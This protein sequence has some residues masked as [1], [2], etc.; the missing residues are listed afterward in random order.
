MNQIIIN[1]FK[2]CYLFIDYVVCEWDVVWI[3]IWLFVGLVS[4]VVVFGDYFLFNIGVELIIVIWIKVG[5]VVVFYN[6]CKYCGNCLVWLEDYIGCVEK[7][8]CLYYV[9]IYDLDG[10]LCLVFDCYCFSN[11][12]FED[13]FF[14]SFFFLEIWYGF[15]FVFMSDNFVFFDEFMGFIMDEL[16]FYY[17]DKFI[18]VVDQFCF[19][20]CNWKVM[21]DNFVEFYYVDFIYFLYKMFVDCLNVEVEFYDYGYIFV[22]VQGGIVNL[23]YLIFDELMEMM[24]VQFFFF[25]VNLLE[26]DGWVLDVCVVI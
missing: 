12:L 6:V 13:R 14:F 22:C 15:I 1:F 7:F 9:W 10:L 20:N 24:K 4:D 16:M 8:C 23:C 2:E 11:G 26:Y 5:D 17:L 25:G 3:E 21:F 18:F 19:Y